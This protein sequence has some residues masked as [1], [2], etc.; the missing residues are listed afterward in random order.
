[1][2]FGILFYLCHIER[3]IRSSQIDL[4]YRLI[5][6]GILKIVFI[7]TVILVHSHRSFT[8]LYAIFVHGV[9]FSYSYMWHL[10]HIPCFFF[11]F[12]NFLNESMHLH[13]LNFLIDVA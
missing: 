1:V 5:V 6:L 3:T 8:L 11:F 13:P 10:T 7:P 4:S 2:T 9:S 12:I